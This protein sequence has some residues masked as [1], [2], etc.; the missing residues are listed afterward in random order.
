MRG[1]WSEEGKGRRVEPAKAGDTDWH[2][3]NHCRICSFIFSFKSG[4]SVSLRVSWVFTTAN[5]YSSSFSA[6]RSLLTLSPRQAMALT[7]KGAPW[8]GEGSC[9]SGREAEGLR[10]G[11]G[12]DPA[13]AQTPAPT[14]SQDGAP[15]RPR[16]HTARNNGHACIRRNCVRSRN[17]SV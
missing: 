17:S 2:S 14:H 5:W 3:I 10:G 11:S 13:R 9:G 8:L 6:W 12:E 15:A 4:P 1:H 7:P 16:T